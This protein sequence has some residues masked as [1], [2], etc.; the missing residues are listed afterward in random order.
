MTEKKDFLY[1]TRAINE[2]GVDGYAYVGRKDG[3]RVV[4][5]SPLNELPGTNPEEL[6]GLSLSTCFNSTVH[7]LLKEDGLT[8]RS[9][10]EVPVRLKKEPEAP[11]YFF[12]VTVQAAIEGLAIR[13]AKEII[14][15]ASEIGRAHV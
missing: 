6:L 13:E 1:E 15:Q 7:A 12:E 8:N 5:S 10:V 9:K 4:V 14:E 3:L 2:D 11:G